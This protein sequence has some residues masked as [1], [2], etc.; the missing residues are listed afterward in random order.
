LHARALG[1]KTG[2]G[3]QFN[4]SITRISNYGSSHSPG[5]ELASVWHLSEKIYA[6]IQVAN[7]LKNKKSAQPSLYTATWGYEASEKLYAGVTIS[8]EEEQPVNVQ[9]AV[10]YRFHPACMARL[11][12]SSATSSAWSGAA[13]SWKN[14]RLDIIAAYHPQLGITPAMALSFIMGGKKNEP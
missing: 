13:L 6:G 4:Y 7:I 3:I 14:S 5:F 9:A 10:Q 8:K 2:V 1:T 12:V 11:G